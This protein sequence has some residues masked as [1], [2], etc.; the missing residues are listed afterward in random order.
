MPVIPSKAPPSAL[1]HG[2]DFCTVRP[3]GT[4]LSIRVVTAW[5]RCKVKISRLLGNAPP[6]ARTAREYTRSF[7]Y[8]IVEM[9]IAHLT[10]DPHTL[11]ACSLTCRSWYIVAVPHI[12]HTLVLKRDVVRG[13]LKPISKL[14]VR[15]LMPLVQEIRVEQSRGTQNNWFVPRAFGYRTLHHFSAFTN[16]HILRLQRLEI[17]RFIPYIER[18]FGQ[19]SATLRSIVL[20]DPCCTPRQLSHFLS[21]FS[22]LEDIKIWGLSTGVPDVA[23]PD[24][25]L[26]PFSTPKLR[27]RL[28]LGVF[29]WVETWTDLAASCGGLQFRHMELCTSVPC[30]SALLEACAETLEILRFYASDRSQSRSFRVCLFCGLELMMNSNSFLLISGI[31]PIAAWGPPIATSHGLDKRLR[32]PTKPSP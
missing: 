2:S 22:T 12:H 13:G 16:V 3:V 5:R 6:E 15:G 11:K 26:A 28:A 9:I 8:E 7:P 25:M 17:Y 1:V 14:H 10:H 23:V 29:S 32:P 19:F 4:N 31:R 20:P 21:F 24:V 27:G 30:T 18:Y